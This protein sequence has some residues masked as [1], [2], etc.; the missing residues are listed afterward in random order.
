MTA[1]SCWE[2]V[3]SW[4]LCRINRLLPLSPLDHPTRYR[5]CNIQTPHRYLWS[6]LEHRPCV[7]GRAVGRNFQGQYGEKKTSVQGNSVKKD[8]LF[9]DIVPRTLGKP[10]RGLK[11]LA[12]WLILVVIC[13]SKVQNILHYRKRFVIWSRYDRRLLVWK[14]RR[15]M[16]HQIL[17]QLKPTSSVSRR[18]TYELVPRLAACRGFSSSWAILDIGAR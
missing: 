2:I 12:T 6:I 15:L 5:R 16:K 18:D 1:L 10:C 17:K 3:D 8:W 13:L 14:A 7:T 11:L 4:C 9:A